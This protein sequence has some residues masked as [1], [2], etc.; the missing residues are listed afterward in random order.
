MSSIF[1]I[2]D[3]HGHDEGFERLLAEAGYRPGADELYIL[4][5]FWDKRMEADAV[6]ASLRK[7]ERWRREGARLLLG[8]HE[9]EWL[10]RCRQ[11]GPLSA[12]PAVR[13]GIELLASLPLFVRTESCL[14]VHAGIR[15]HV[16]LDRQTAE[17]L[18]H[19]REPF[20]SPDYVP[21]V[22]TVFGHTSTDLIG[23]E[24]GQVYVGPNK[25]GIDTGAKHGLRLSLVDLT[26]RR[27]YSCSTAQDR[28]YEEL[29]VTDLPICSR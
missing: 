9:W 4:G 7:I 17:D 13:S 12:D 15:P 11:P 27:V 29:T 23:S 25:I 10:Q 18:T 22:L 21:P 24:P 5:D 16:E 19:I 8:N 1:A 14:Y 28:M 26:R 2:S 3:I 6:P 20:L